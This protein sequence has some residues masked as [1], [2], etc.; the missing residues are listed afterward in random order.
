MTV[1]IRPGQSQGGES[2]FSYVSGV[3]I[4]VVAHA[5]DLIMVTVS[6]SRIGWQLSQGLTGLGRSI[7]DQEINIQNYYNCCSVQ[8]D[9]LLPIN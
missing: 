7:L 3:T 9:T 4:M 8:F 2:H 1:I 5:L 6:E